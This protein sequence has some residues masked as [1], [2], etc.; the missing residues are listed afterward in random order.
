MTKLKSVHSG[1][2]RNPKALTLS[3]L[4]L[5]SANRTAKPGWQHNCSL[6]GLLD[7]SS[8]L[9]RPTIRKKIPFNILLPLT[10]HLVT[11]ELWWRWTMRCMLISSCNTASIRQLVDQGVILSFKPHLLKNAFHKRLQLP[12]IVI[13]LMDVGKVN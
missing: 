7:I 4:C 9:L 1:H 12:Q 5:C 10:M 13:P 2:S 11:Q 3:L 8:P 6:H